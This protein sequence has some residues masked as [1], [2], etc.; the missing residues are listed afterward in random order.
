MSSRLP[1]QGKVKRTAPGAQQAFA[2]AVQSNLHVFVAWDLQRGGAS[3][4]GVGGATG[5][6][7]NDTAKS[8][9]P[10]RFAY[11]CLFIF[12][13]LGIIMK[14]VCRIHNCLCVMI[15]NIIFVEVKTCNTA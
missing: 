9:S 7:V 13:K 6:G 1:Q 12:L 3:F 15:Y 8:G 11:T 5:W 10:L 2:R 4:G 14:F